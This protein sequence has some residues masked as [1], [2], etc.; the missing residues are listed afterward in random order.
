MGKFK[1]FSLDKILLFW[2]LGAALVFLVLFVLRRGNYR[3]FLPG[4]TTL[5]F[6]QWWEDELEGESL[7]KLIALFEEQNP[8]VRIKL[9]KKTRAEI[10]TEL[11]DMLD[12][13]RGAPQGVNRGNVSGFRTNSAG[14]QADTKD[15]R[16]L[17][18]EAKRKKE[19]AEKRK[20]KSSKTD[21]YSLEGIWLDDFSK[22]LVPVSVKNDPDI[23]WFGPA[24]PVISF[25]TPLF[26]NIHI[27][28]ASGFDRPPKN[29]TE[30]LSYVQAISKPAENPEQYGVIFAL[31]DDP[32]AASRYILSWIW[33]AGL[34]GLAADGKYNSEDSGV[35]VL[36]EDFDFGST[37]V[38]DTLS[39]LNQL[40][41][42]LY[43]DPFSI[44]EESKVRL[45]M[46]GK[47]GMMIGPVSDIQKIRNEMK[48]SFGITTIPSPASYVGK[49]VFALSS[50]YAGINAESDGR[51]KAE[52]FL[53][54]LAEHSSE[55][56]KNAFAVPGNGERDSELMKDD[57]YYAKAHE[58]FDA[59]EM[60]EEVYGRGRVKKLNAIILEETRRMFEGGSP[61]AAAAA[62]Q[63]R[64]KFIGK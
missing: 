40:K 23:P 16:S 7:E 2:A 60:V 18:E 28:Q 24:L 22:V 36:S 41:P 50:W 19:K 1:S 55:L 31:A 54:F 57:P 51:E 6:S 35:S 20:K 14:G 38:K 56:A 5:V 27:L 12:A 4:D 9:Q 49:P 11:D 47:A 3:D 32:F 42:Y 52:I 30:F 46:E 33:A 53:A 37:K 25:I 39:F 29:Q 8:D 48:D 17:Q 21:I 44:D 61:E 43:P 45:F 15:S 34:E 64:W 58:M 26:Y 59:G 62:I 10:K 63:I 13:V